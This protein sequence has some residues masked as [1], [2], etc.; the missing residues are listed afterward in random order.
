MPGRPIVVRRFTSA[1]EDLRCHVLFISAT[2]SPEEQAAV[3]ERL[4]GV[5]VL[6]V[7]EQPGF[8]E[9]GGTVNF[10]VAENKLRFEINLETAKQDRLKISSKLLRLAKIVGQT[11]GSLFNTPT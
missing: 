4:R 2:V 10:F 3:F 7:G 5:S 6:L 9:Q 11:V 8:A 1:D